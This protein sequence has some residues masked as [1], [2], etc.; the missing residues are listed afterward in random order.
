MQQDENS[1]DEDLEW[2]DDQEGNV[3]P[4][5]PLDV[6]EKSRSTNW[7]FNLQKSISKLIFAGYIGCKNPVRNRLKI[8]FVKLDFFNLFF[9]KSSTYRWIGR[10]IGPN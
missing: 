10:R 7:I 8:Q 4:N 1:V 6:D 2:E 3:E 5:V 9:Q